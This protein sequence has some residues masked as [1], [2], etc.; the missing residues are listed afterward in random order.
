MR[1]YLNICY[2]WA[3]LYIVLSHYSLSGEVKMTR[4]IDTDSSAC[5]ITYLHSYLTRDQ[6]CTIAQRIT[7]FGETPCKQIMVSSF[8]ISSIYIIFTQGKI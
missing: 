6:W 4:I 5:N 3:E 2:T 8:F 1:S 7:N